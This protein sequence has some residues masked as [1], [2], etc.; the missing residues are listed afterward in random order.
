MIIELPED[1]K[2]LLYV[3]VTR[4]KKY[5]VVSDMVYNVLSAAHDGYLERVQVSSDDQVGEN[6]GESCWF[7]DEEIKV[8]PR[9]QLSTYKFK[10]Y[11][12]RT[13]TP[14]LS[15]TGA[16]K[17][18]AVCHKDYLP[19]GHSRMFLLSVCGYRNEKEKSEWMEEYSMLDGVL[20]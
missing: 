4:A 3:A 9:F 7:H 13:N 8:N 10:E 2:N 19:H 1:K 16:K 20:W 17:G 15:V 6:L 14:G 18:G 12:F 11:N 5:L